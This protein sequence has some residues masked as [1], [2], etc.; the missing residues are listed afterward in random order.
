MHLDIELPIAILSLLV[1]FFT[2]WK[3][4][5]ERGKL[6]MTQPATIFFGPDSVENIASSKVHLKTLLFSTSERGQVVEGMYV[7]LHRGESIQIFN[8]WAYED[9]KDVV[10]GSGLYVGKQ[11]VAYSH[12]FFPPKDGSTYEF[13]PGKYRLE[14]YAS[15]L[16]KPQPIKTF[17]VDLT[18]SES[19]AEKLKDGR[20]GLY[21]DW[22]PE[23]NQYHPH[24]HFKEY[25]AAELARKLTG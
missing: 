11:G 9:K 3:M 24:L 12:T 14:V 20:H 4:Y 17:S 2:L 19:Q 23:S 15:V 10:R 5:L 7:R 18:I 1:S 21:F 8:I 22:G 16:N 25:T 6:K 13:L